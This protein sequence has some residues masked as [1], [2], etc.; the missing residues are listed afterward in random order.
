MGHLPAH[1][2]SV[3]L[4]LNP[5]TELVLLVSPQFHV[6]VDDDFSTVP[7]LGNGSVPGNWHQLVCNSGEKNMN[8]FYDVTKAWL[9]AEHDISAGD[10]TKAAESVGQRA[11]A[12]SPNAPQVVEHIDGQEDQPVPPPTEAS[13][14]T[15]GGLPA[16]NTP[17]VEEPTDTN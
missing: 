17:G 3:A 16:G 7:S 2:G 6:V 13:T 12:G 11:N 5:K 14:E 10:T 15:G 1:T 8:G 4:V 9:T